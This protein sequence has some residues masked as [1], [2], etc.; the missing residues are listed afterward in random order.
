MTDCS[1]TL[2]AVE[3]AYQYAKN[4]IDL[5]DCCY[6][7]HERASWL[8]TQ[9]Y[10]FFLAG[11]VAQLQ[12]SRILEIGAHFGGSIFSMARGVEHAGL[13]P[14]AQIVTVDLEDRNREAFQRKRTVRRIIGDCSDD[15]TAHNVALSFSEHVDLMFIDHHHDYEHTNH[16]LELY[17]P[18][19]SPRLVIID[20]I[21]LN[22]SMAK[23]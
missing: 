14:S 2:R 1:S 3:S 17:L 7:P 9:E 6:G 23:L 15:V 20:D 4:H 22:A 16:C 21:R 8:G 13:L 12:C 10:Y 11:L 5:S 18:L 19:V